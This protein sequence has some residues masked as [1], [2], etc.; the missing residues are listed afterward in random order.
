MSGQR[1]RNTRLRRNGNWP[2]ATQEVLIHA[3]VDGGDESVNA[4][5]K[6]IANTDFD[7][8]EYD[9]FRMIGLIYHNLSR[10]AAKEPNLQRMKGIFRRTWYKNQ[11]LL[12]RLSE[13]VRLFRENE[14]DLLIIKGAPISLLYYENSGSR[15]MYDLDILVKPDDAIR[16]IDL[17][18]L[19]GWELLVSESYD[20]SSECL[21]AHYATHLKDE[22]GIELDLH[23]Y[24]LKSCRFDTA[25]S[26]FW[27]RSVP[28][29]I[30]GE[31]SR[32]LDS[33]GHLLHMCVHGVA[34]HNTSP[35]RWVTDAMTIFNSG[36]EVD[37]DYLEHEIHKRQLNSLMRDALGYLRDEFDAQIPDDFLGRLDT[38]GTRKRQDLELWASTRVE[39]Q[40]IAALTERWA[41][42]ARRA[43]GNGGRATITGFLQFLQCV[44]EVNSSWSL[45]G[46]AV[47]K[48]SRRFKEAIRVRWSCQVAK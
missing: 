28:I 31:A 40:S 43:E 48:F 20:R 44:W 19:N 35:L 22:N 4:W 17:L 2:S 3:A 6:W 21:G 30:N 39:R 36:A 26:E 7:D 41:T 23:W 5:R 47:K 46:T 14:V 34:S 37:W 24:A 1:N 33:A 18:R 8:I 13:V 29:E 45:P 38:F 25:D 9:S 16:S 15:Q 10:S 32:T 27:G 12:N 11:V 42:Y